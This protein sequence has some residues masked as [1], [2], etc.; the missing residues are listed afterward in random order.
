MRTLPMAW[1]LSTGVIMSENAA[2]TNYV[3]P[4]P[5]IFAGLVQRALN[6]Q[7]NNTSDLLKLGDRV[8]ALELKGTGLTLFFKQEDGQL[9]VSAEPLTEVATWIRGTPKALFGM[10]KPEWSSSSD[11][12]IIEGDAGLV[13]DFEALMK[14]LDFDWEQKL[15]E[16]VGDVAAHQLGIFVN[17]AAKFVKTTVELGGQSAKDT[18]TKGVRKQAGNFVSTTE[19][20]EFSEQLE[21]LSAA[22]A[23]LADKID[24]QATEERS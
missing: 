17:K 13:R 14:S 15:S 24:N 2:N 3:T 9:L 8:L 1:L 20:S 4:L 16:L 6:E 10:A 12:V 7:F 23:K 18:L 21:S 19:F 11:Q 5:G 22:L